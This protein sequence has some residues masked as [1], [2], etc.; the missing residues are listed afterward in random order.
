MFDCGSK[1][2]LGFTGLVDDFEGLVISIEYKTGEG[3]PVVRLDIGDTEGFID[4]SVGP[5]D[6]FA[7]AFDSSDDSTVELW[8]DNFSDASE[9]MAICAAF[10][11]DP[12]S[13]GDVGG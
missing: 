2:S 9:L 12:F 11:E 10:F 3:F 4:I 8:P 6:I 7:E 13:G 5:E 1:N